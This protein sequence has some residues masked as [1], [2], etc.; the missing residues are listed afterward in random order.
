MQL[1]D[2]GG[3]QGEC[4][5]VVEAQHIVSTLKLVEGLQEQ[6]IL[7][8]ILEETKPTLPSDCRGLHY[9]FSTPFRYDALYPNGSRFRRAGKT[10]GVYYASEAQETAI[11][12]IVFYRFLFFSESP[13][14]L[15]PE[16]ATDYTAVG[17]LL[18][19]NKVI[20]LTK[21]PFLAHEEKWIDLLAY[22]ACQNLAE[23]A[24]EIHTDIIRFQSVRDP[25]K[26]ANLAVLNCAAFKSVEPSS[27]T[28][29][30]LTYRHKRIIAIREFP[31]KALEF[32]ADSFSDPRL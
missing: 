22:E 8:D 9:L 12:E 19:S 29:W 31:R 20:D 1:S 23:D 15:L 10:A 18:A 11:A 17:A 5:R 14:T 7:E 2:F 3:W 24:R 26:Q 27:I 32:T 28:G 4:W 13:D 30:S 25:D 21:Q 6:Q 16:N